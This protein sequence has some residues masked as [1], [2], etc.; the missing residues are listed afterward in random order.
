[1][2][3]KPLWGLSNYSYKTC[4][5][6]E[7][8]SIAEFHKFGRSSEQGP[9][10]RSVYF[11]LPHRPRAAL[12]DR[13]DVAT[14]DIYSVVKGMTW[15][16]LTRIPFEQT[17]EQLIF[18]VAHLRATVRLCLPFIERKVLPMLPHGLCN[19]LCSLNPRLGSTCDGFSG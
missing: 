9:W 15:V 4:T 5:Q 3:V 19:H 13:H 16:P 11:S 1:M 8:A 12:I 6:G 18:T 14:I 7:A 17:R 2:F 10:F